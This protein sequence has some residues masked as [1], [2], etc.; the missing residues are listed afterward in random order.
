MSAYNFQK[1]FA[2]AIESGE[3]TSTIRARRKNGYV[4]V[5]GER[6]KLYTGQ[7]T[8]KCRLLREVTVSRVTPIV[9]DNDSII[10]DGTP[11]SA[12]RCLRIAKQDGFQ[13][14]ADFVS[15][16]KEQRGLPFNGY[17]IEWNP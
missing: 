7:R 10:L 4:P 9:V 12:V 2:P 8:T 6:I 15:F 5:P 13:S 1:Q 3:K 16:F 17:L 14:W 11:V